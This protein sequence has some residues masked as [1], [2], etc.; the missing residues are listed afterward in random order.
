MEISYNGNSLT[1]ISLVVYVRPVTDNGIIC[2]QPG[3][4]ETQETYIIE[5]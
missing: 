1:D 2:E 5:K 3:P 4:G